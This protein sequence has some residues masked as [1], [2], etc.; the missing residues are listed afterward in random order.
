MSV[1]QPPEDRKEVKVVGLDLS[2]TATGVAVAQKNLSPVR[3]VSVMSL[4][5]LHADRTDY[6]GLHM[7]LGAVK[8][9]PRNFVN[10]FERINKIIR[11]IEVFVNVCSAEEQEPDLWVLED[12]FVGP[13]ARAAIELTELGAV[14]RNWLFTTGRSFITIYPSQL[15]KFIIG[16][17]TG[18]KGLVMMNVFKRWGV[19]VQENNSADAAVAANAGIAILD[20]Y[21]H[22]DWKYMTKPQVEVVKKM[23]EETPFVNQKHEL[24]SK[25]P[26]KP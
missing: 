7:R 3:L 1:Q 21:L 6:P 4:S 22:N 5:G 26:K 9:S 15:K 13:H 2:L 24:W 14:V 8:T 19:E 18:D 11:E 16:K 10:T 23:T 17:G 20:Y 12:Y 25:L